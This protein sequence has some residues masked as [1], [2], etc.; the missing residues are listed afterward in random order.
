VP[1]RAIVWELNVSGDLKHD[2][3]KGEDI[4]WFIVLTQED[5][6]AD[7]FAIAFAFNTWFCRPRCCHAKVSNLQDTFKGDENIGGLE[8]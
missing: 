8:I 5:L 2:E 4:S 1:G 7:V 6:G 3:A